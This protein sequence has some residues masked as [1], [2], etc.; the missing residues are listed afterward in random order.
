MILE[1]MPGG[2]LY[3]RILKDEKIYE[4]EMAFVLQGTLRA[5]AYLHHLGKIHRFFFFFFRKNF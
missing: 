2:S 5:I 1:F 4:T 3:H